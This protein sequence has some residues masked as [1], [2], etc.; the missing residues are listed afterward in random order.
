M[1]IIRVTEM[2]KEMLRRDE[3]RNFL[4]FSLTWVTCNLKKN[5]GGEKITLNKAVFVGGQSERGTERNPNHAKNFTRNIRHLNS[6][7]IMTIHPL[8][9]TLF[10]G[11]QV[12]Q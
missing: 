11:K 10:N 12:A 2:L 6:D 8:L 7:R 9:V 5:E 4:P 3:N 1:E